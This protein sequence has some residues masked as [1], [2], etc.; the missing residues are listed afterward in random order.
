MSRETLHICE[1]HGVD[2]DEVVHVQHVIGAAQLQAARRLLQQLQPSMQLI[3]KNVEHSGKFPL[4]ANSTISRLAQFDRMRID[5]YVAS[6]RAGITSSTLVTNINHLTAFRDIPEDNLD[7]PF[8]DGIAD[9]FLTPCDAPGIVQMSAQFEPVVLAD[10][11]KTLTFK[12][13]CKNK[14]HREIRV[15][16]ADV[17]KSFNDRCQDTK[18]YAAIIRRVL[19]TTKTARIT[20]KTTRL[21]GHK[22]WIHL[23]QEAERGGLLTL[24]LT[25]AC[26][27]RDQK[28]TSRL[29]IVAA[30]VRVRMLDVDDMVDASDECVICFERFGSDC[31]QCAGCRNRLHMGCFETWKSRGG[32]DCP[33]CRRHI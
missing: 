2:S 26:V 29:A 3:Y 23:T 4:S 20:T 18:K 30:D 8:C 9:A 1:A 25:R 11:N 28:M 27:V 17:Y 32:V 21:A 16:C 13:V 19:D 6:C 5:A 10:H 14:E 15:S 33:F 22:I 31:W 24:Y 12:L 7:V